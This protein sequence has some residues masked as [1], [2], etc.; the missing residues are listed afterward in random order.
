MA[1]LSLFLKKGGDCIVK[2]NLEKKAN[3]QGVFLG[4]VRRKLIKLQCDGWVTNLC[5]SVVKKQ[6][7]CESAFLWGTSFS[8]ARH[9]KFFSNIS[10]Y[11]L[12]QKYCSEIDVIILRLF[13]TGKEKQEKKIICYA[14]VTTLFLNLFLY[15]TLYHYSHRI[16][17]VG[18][19]KCRR[20]Y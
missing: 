7:N 3:L 16:M 4:T 5:F 12:P 11:F 13:E 19:G 9:L 17:S 8:H 1:V 18:K 15:A 2:K 20:G 10:V 14:Q 6:K